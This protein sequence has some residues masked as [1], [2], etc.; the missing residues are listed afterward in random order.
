MKTY[1]KYKDSGIEWIGEIPE[2]WEANK[3]KYIASVR[4]SGVDKKSHEDETPIRLC[5]YTDVYYKEYIDNGIDFMEATASDNE[6]DYATLKQG[7][8]LITKD[9]ETPDDIAVPAFVKDSLEN[10]LCGYH[11]AM[12]RPIEDLTEGEYIFRMFCAQTLRDQF[13]PCAN[14]IT[15]FGV[16]KFS[17]DNS[18]FT[19]PPNKEQKAIASFLDL[20]TKQIDELI[21]KK[22]R[23][24][25]LL[26]EQRTAIINHAVT[27]GLNPNTPMK[28]SDIEWLG[29]IPEQWAL[30]KFSH[31]AP[32]ITC[33]LASTPEYHNNGMPFLSAQNIRNSKLSLDKYNFISNELHQKLTKHRKPIKGDILVTR[34]GAGIGE[35]C[36][37]DIDLEFSIYVSLTHIRVNDDIATNKFIMYFFNTKYCKT[38]NEFGTVVGGGV[39]NLNVK[40][41]ERY[42]IPLPPINE[43]EEIVN[44]LDKSL[45][46]IDIAINKEEKSISLLQEYRTT[47]ISNAVTGKIDV[48]EN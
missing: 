29:K 4:L 44:Y 1:P 47:L 12:I 20:K 42:I 45:Y 6:I 22:R 31:I 30:W 5:N 21:E 46:E 43:Q 24:I 7:D 2:H 27:K 32:I 48:R 36:I 38:L 10:V 18:L 28:D 33:G 23:M 16:G 3:L 25:E 19:L 41:L 15:R 34:V 8:V 37:I 17:I 26:K 13:T 14:G 35:A 11:L 40:N 39:G 9:S